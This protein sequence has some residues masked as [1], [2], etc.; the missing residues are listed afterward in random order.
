MGASYFVGWAG[1]VIVAGAGAFALATKEERIAPSF[2]HPWTEYPQP[3]T[4]VR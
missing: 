1:L 3:L 4:D 2:D